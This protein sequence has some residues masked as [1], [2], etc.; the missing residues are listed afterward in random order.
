MTLDATAAAIVAQI[1]VVM[2]R[3][4]TEITDASQARALMATPP[5]TLADPTPVGSV[6]NRTVPGP[7]GRTVPVRIYRPLNEP[8]A[9]PPAMVF[10]HGG[11]W[12][13]GDLDGHDDICRRLAN[14]IGCVVIS[15]DYRLA[16]EHPFPEPLEDVYAVL[17]WAAQQGD[18]LLVDTE[19]LVL[20]GDS[21]GGNLAAAA[22][23][24]ARDQGGP[25]VA[26]QLLIYPV[27]DADF[28]RASYVE[29]AKGYPLTAEHM[30]WYWDQYAIVTARA[31]PYA[32]PLQTPNLSGLPPA[33]VIT[34][35]YDVLRDEGENYAKRLH[36]AGVPVTVQRYPGAFHGFF[37]F[38]ALLPIARE[39]FGEAVAQVR[40][41]LHRS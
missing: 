13:F 22:A 16:P 12:V 19:R 6:A 33:H 40:A 9:P 8:A 7:Q 28:T 26:F 23:L 24:L 3:I 18:S 35:E 31:E 36:E 39:A 21:A 32:A 11:G 30:R 25:H 10:C 41:V 27:L 20:A 15:V 5:A 1:D 17:K 34:A 14:R 29:N 2:S 37:G 4:G 38:G